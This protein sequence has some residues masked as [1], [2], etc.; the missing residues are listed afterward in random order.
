MGV[1]PDYLIPVNKE[2]IPKTA[3]GKIQRSQL[4]QRFNTGEFKPI[5]KQIDILLGNANTIPDWFYRQVWKPKS[6]ITGIHDNFFE[7]GGIPC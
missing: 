4:S 1:N 3:I 5:I 6:P 7:L 2:I